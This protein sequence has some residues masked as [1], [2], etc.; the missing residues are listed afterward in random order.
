M[1]DRHADDV[2]C[3]HYHARIT[4]LQNEL[5]DVR[6]KVRD[7]TKS[8]E[9]PPGPLNLVRVQTYLEDRVSR[10]ERYVIRLLHWL[11]P[12][13]LCKETRPRVTTDRARPRPLFRRL[14]EIFSAYLRL[15]RRR[16]NKLKA[17]NPSNPKLVGS[18]TS[19]TTANWL[20]WLITAHA[21]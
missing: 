18:G 9:V 8:N 14:V 16:L 15:F 2:A 20:L 11:I 13:M 7:A 19:P 12:P 10:T 5:D 1:V 3:E 4:T 17:P 6:A 21:T